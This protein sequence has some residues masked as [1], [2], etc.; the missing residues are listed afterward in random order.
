MASCKPCMSDAIL[1]QRTKLNPARLSQASF[2]NR[3]KTMSNKFEH[4][5]DDLLGLPTTEL[6]IYEMSELLKLNI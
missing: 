5:C 1:I 3:K 2:L 6:N 4:Y